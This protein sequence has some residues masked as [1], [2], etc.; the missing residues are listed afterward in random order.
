VDVSEFRVH[1]KCRMVY[2]EGEAAI[3]LLPGLYESCARTVNIFLGKNELRK[4]IQR[5]SPSEGGLI[6]PVTG[7]PAD[8]ISGIPNVRNSVAS[9]ARVKPLGRRRVTW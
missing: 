7:H 3:V 2:S 8:P 1:L 6:D 4:L 9:V 5:K